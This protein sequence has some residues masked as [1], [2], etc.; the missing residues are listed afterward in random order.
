MGDDVKWRVSAVTGRPAVHL[1]LR[2]V[3]WYIPTNLGK[4]TRALSCQRVVE[5]RLQVLQCPVI[6]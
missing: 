6:S 3:R 5:E 4:P 1:E 2:A